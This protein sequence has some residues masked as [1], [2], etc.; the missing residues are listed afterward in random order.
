M[1]RKA[2]EDWIIERLTSAHER[3]SFDCRKPSLNEF[4]RRLAN[5]Y[6]RRDMGRTYV[7][8]LPNSPLVC[9][10][11]T[12]ATGAVFLDNLPEEEQKKLPR[13]PVPV[14]HL[15]RIAVDQ[16]VRGKGLGETLLI[17]ALRRC[18]RIAEEVGLFAVEVYA[19]DEEAR[20]LYLRYGFTSLLDDAK[21]LYLPIK[22]V[23]KM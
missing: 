23:R 2:S 3:S 7:A 9:G 1:A 13:H 16:T 8:V 4:F 17:D 12:L 10:Y 5:Q 6:D 14:A 20:N 19:L 22:V 11:Y 21:H 18:L 15:G